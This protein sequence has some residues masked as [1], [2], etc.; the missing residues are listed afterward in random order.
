MEYLPYFSQGNGWISWNIYPILARG[1]GGSHGVFTL[2]EPG[3]WVDL[4]EYL[5]Y[6]SQENGWISW[7]IYPILTRGMGGSHGIFTLF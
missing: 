2:F 5:S 1:M 4:M 6:L 3:E 7:N